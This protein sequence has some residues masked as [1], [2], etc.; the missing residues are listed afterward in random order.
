MNAKL[1]PRKYKIEHD[2]N[3]Y[4]YF[5]EWII[6]EHGGKWAISVCGAYA[7]VYLTNKNALDFLGH[8]TV[9]CDTAEEAL[10]SWKKYIECR[11]LGVG[12]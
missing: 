9:L 10:E 4:V 2:V 11:G 8:D 3:D 12:T 1:V 5:I 6:A 7:D